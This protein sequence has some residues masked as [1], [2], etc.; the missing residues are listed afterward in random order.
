[1]PRLERGY[2]RQGSEQKSVPLVDGNGRSTEFS[3]L[4]ELD[5]FE[6]DVAAAATTA[7]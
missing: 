6:G 7:V 4:E 5:V 1:M 2:H 3:G